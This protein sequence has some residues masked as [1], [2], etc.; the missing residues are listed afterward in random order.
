MFFPR[1]ATQAEYFDS[2]ERTH[3]ELVEGYAS[4]A[5][6]NRWFWFS[7]PFQRLMPKFIGRDTCKTLSILDLGAGDGM[8]GRVLADWA[9]R[10]RNWDW[11]FTN[12][13]VNADALALNPA[14][15]NVVGSALNLPFPDGSF[16]VVI[17][18]QMTHH[19]SD[20][21][22]VQHLREAWR[23]TRRAIYLTD[24]HRSPVL[25]ALLKV[26]FAVRR[27]PKH[28][29]NDGLLSVKRGFRVRELKLLAKQ[30]GIP[31]AR[32]SVYYGTRILIRAK[33]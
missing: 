19:F 16:D 15:R 33:K 20:E 32:I 21:E 11:Q 30:A 18:S 4:L 14:G 7:E 12:L 22:V 10:K 2:P 6:V 5:R 29:E 25:Y 31:D 3:A 24:L 9:K 13:D 23:V 27:F 26:M 17:A 1:R 28:F 8:L